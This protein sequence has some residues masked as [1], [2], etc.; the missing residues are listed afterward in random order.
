MKWSTIGQWAWNA[1]QKPD[2]KDP[3]ERMKRAYGTYRDVGDACELANEV[4][5][6]TD[7]EKQT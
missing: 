2:P 7:R 5:K 4:L 6:L 1:L 3:F